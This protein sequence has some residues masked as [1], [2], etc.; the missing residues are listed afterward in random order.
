VAAAIYRRGMLGDVLKAA[1][2][3]AGLTQEELAVRAKLSR[4]YVS[5][6]ERGQQSPTVD[7]LFRLAAILGIKAS[8]LLSRVE[9]ERAENLKR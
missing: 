3:D 5:K 9:Q 6:L 8:V 1:R 2:H 4:E 7:T